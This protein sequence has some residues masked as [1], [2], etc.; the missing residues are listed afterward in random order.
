MRAE[1]RSTRQRA[2]VTVLTNEASFDE[3]M[4]AYMEG[5][6]TWRQLP[7][8]PAEHGAARRRGGPG[9]V[10]RGVRMMEKRPGAWRRSSRIAVVPPGSVSTDELLAEVLCL[11]RQDRFG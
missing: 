6:F 4:T 1:N 10:F 2:V 3:L 11:S 7:R 9:P 8:A 5:A